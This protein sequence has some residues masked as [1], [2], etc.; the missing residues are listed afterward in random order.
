VEIWFAEDNKYQVGDYWLIPARV[1]TGDVEWPRK[2]DPDGRSLAAAMPPN[3]PQHYFA[4]LMHVRK[5][6]AQNRDCRCRIRHLPCEE[7]NGG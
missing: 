2:V 1:A 5:D 7:E 4:P 3:G 6:G